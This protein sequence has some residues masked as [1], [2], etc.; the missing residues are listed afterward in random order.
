MRYEQH[1][2]PEGTVVGPP[3]VI[4]PT[5]VR[6]A[7]VVE[8][9]VVRP[10][11]VVQPVAPSSA[12]VE[13]LG[14]DETYIAER[15]SVGYSFRRTLGAWVGLA[16]TVVVSILALRF[17]LKLTAANEGNGFVDFIYGLSGALVA[18][19]EGIFSSRAAGSD[20]VF[21]PAVL[22]AIA[23]YAL[24]AL[25]MVALVSALAAPY[26]GGRERSVRRTSIHDEC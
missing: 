3:T 12:P 9:V 13:R 18:P 5:A 26:E 17:F 23:V 20:G 21:E 25:L 16:L 2:V 11:T 6:P 14:V 19:F 1:E 10:A 15:P 24:I 22:V 4:E 7:T 8:P